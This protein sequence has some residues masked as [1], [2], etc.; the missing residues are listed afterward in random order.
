MMIWWC[1]KKGLERRMPVR[2]LQSEE[3]TNLVVDDKIAAD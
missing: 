3:K 1:F 2:V